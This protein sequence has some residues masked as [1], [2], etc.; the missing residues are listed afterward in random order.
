[1]RVG[2]LLCTI[3]LLAVLTATACGQVL[4]PREHHEWGR[5]PVGS[6]KK[7]RLVTEQLDPQGR[8][9]STNTRLVTTTVTAVNNASVELQVA[10]VVE[11]AGKEFP[12]KPQV[13]TQDFEGQV[14]GEPAADDAHRLVKH[15]GSEQIEIDGEAVES[16][17]RTVT[18]RRNRSRLISRINYCSSLAPYILRRE[19]SR[20][21]WRTA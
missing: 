16:E 20:R 9:I 1:M 19:I 11:L 12:K 5:F 13:V 10:T 2:I 15:L 8:V 4:I 18:V 21:T 3:P 17:V 6:W 14:D 7:V